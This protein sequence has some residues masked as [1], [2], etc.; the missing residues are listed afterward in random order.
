MNFATVPPWRS[1]TGFIASKYSVMTW[2]RVSGSSASPSAVEP[3]TSEN[4]MLTTL[5]KRS[6]VSGSASFAPHA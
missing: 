5:R 3:T 1:T 2:E 6:A 4:R